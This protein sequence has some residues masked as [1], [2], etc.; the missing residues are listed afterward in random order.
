MKAFLVKL[1]TDRKTIVA[2]IGALGFATWK[3]SQGDFA[4]AVA[5]AVPALNAL[6]LHLSWPAAAASEDTP[7][8]K[9]Q[10]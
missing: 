4:A 10:P 6:G 5:A 1:Y 2:S 3:L 8:P 9:E 7:A